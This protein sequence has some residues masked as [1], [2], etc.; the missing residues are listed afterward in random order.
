[1]PFWEKI[2]VAN[3]NEENMKSGRRKIDY[4]ECGSAGVER[5]FWDFGSRKGK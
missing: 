4:R 3:W 2:F 1:M 5:G